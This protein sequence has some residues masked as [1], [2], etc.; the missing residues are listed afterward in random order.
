M[1]ADCI[2]SLI[3]ENLRDSLDGK[4]ITYNGVSHTITCERQRL[5]LNI[6]DRYPYVEILGPF[7][8]V[9]DRSN[10]SMDTELRFGL[11]F[12][13]DTI[14]D[15]SGDE[16]ARVLDNVAAD[17][18]SLVMSDITRGGYALKTDYDGYGYF[19]SGE[20]SQPQAC[21]YIDLTVQA[22]ISA[23]NPYQIGA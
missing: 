17:I 6:N 13:E 7:A 18:I 14:N 1:M 8:S 21:V 23:T 12:Y 19:M 2:A 22:Y 11:I 16:I 15:D 10:R 5:R 4:T 3:A 20:P 9:Q